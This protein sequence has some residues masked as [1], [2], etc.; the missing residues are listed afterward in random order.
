MNPMI[1]IL[2]LA[3]SLALTPQGISAEEVLDIAEEIQSGKSVR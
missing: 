3:S 1:A 2:T